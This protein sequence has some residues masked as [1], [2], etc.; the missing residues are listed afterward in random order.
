[1]AD[2]PRTVPF[3]ARA[4]V[5]GETFSREL[6]QLRESLL[7][8]AGL[9]ESQIDEALLALRSF[10][11]VAANRVRMQDQSI[12]ELFRQLR[13]RV[14]QV[15]SAQRLVGR[16]LRTLMGVQYIAI[17]LE[18]IGD[19]AVRIGRRTST[20]ASLPHGPLRPEFGLMGE[21]AS[22]QVRDILDALIEE[23]PARAREVAAKD[24][25]IDRLY[26]RLFDSLVEDFGQGADAEDALRVV[27]L[28]NIAHNLERIGDRV[29]NVAEDIIFLDSGQVV[30]LG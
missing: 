1:M 11:R 8:M 10:D 27:T 22:Q 18:R 15:I 13:E 24:D 9:V 26:H 2:N 19:Y 6:E 21:L 4:P 3:L 16:D 12:N 28:I 20:L 30:E 14:F 23:D 7:R 25:E 17:E 29:V 5:T